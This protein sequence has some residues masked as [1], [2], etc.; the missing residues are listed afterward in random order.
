MQLNEFQK[1]IEKFKE[2]SDKLSELH[3]L[4]FDFYEGKYQLMSD[5]DSMFDIIISS[6]YTNEG[7][8]WIN[9]FIYETDFGNK[10]LEAFDENKNPICYDINSLYEYI[11]KHHKK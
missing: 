1:L 9:W 5:V 11:E 4:G 8:D 7:V 10:K 3:D 6:L 2:T